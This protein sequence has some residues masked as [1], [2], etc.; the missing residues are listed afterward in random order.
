LALA[1][2]EVVMADG[3]DGI[4]T[5]REAKPPG[6]KRRV[7]GRVLR[8]GSIT[9]VAVLILGLVGG[10]LKYRSVW[11]SIKRV[12]VTVLGHRPP[13]YATNALN[14]LVFGSDS[15][16]GLTRHQQLK[17]HVG[18]NQ[19]EVNTDTIMI[20]HISPG[21][22]LVTVIDIPR[23]TVVPIYQCAKVPGYP[24]QQ[25]TPGYIERI[26][27]VMASGG[28]ACLWQTVEQQ[29]HIRIDHF[30]ELSFSGFVHVINDIGGVNVCVPFRVND[31]AS[32]LRLTRGEHH[33]RGVMALKFWRTRE[34]IGDGSDLERIQR[35]Q[36]L[37]S[38]LVQGVLHADLL[39]DP[40]KLL[41]VVSD[42][43]KAMTTDSGLTQSDLFSIA[44]SL[45]SLNSQ[46]VQFIT[47]PNTPYPQNDAEVEFAQ[48]QANEVFGA[49]AHDRKL[50]S[51]KASPSP[52]PSGGPPVVLAANPKQVK[53]TVLNGSGVEGQAGSTA[54]ALG[55]RGFTVLG[56]GD[57]DISTASVIEYRS[58]A[59]RSEV[60]TLRQQIPGIRLQRVPG[61]EPGTL[62]LVLGTSF[63]GLKASAPTPAPKPSGPSV[64]DLSK[65]YGG[66]TADAACK[67]DT[68]AFSGP[69]SP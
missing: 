60:K 38:Q 51:S 40:A 17:L 62:T 61:L 65:S 15:R 30:I 44:A 32:G 23:D 36:F 43:A 5:G 49:I 33:V 55:Q 59:E 19:G 45:R 42:A 63:S 53:V 67:S 29:T 39:G 1:A 6:R 24:G 50:P 13:K 14:L 54:A 25:A 7:V 22:H 20:V 28:P 12:P 10:Y 4:P 34:D 56:T 9:L 11:N 58:R 35:D 16:A 52:S 18:T 31:P 69:L 27:S 64:G 26:N 37:M 2:Q 68:H 66:I 21:R 57:A 41:S 48:P 46:D 8:W 47:A 3:E